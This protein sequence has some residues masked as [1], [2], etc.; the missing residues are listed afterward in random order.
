MHRNSCLLFKRY[1]SAHIRPG[2]RV[3]EV[4]PD[5][6]PSSYRRLT[7]IDVACWDSVDFP[8]RV[9]VTYELAEPY[10]FPIPDESYDV[11]LSG[12]V[13]EHVPKIWRWMPELARVTRPGGHIITV[14]PVSWP[15]HEAPHDCWR[16]YPAGLSAL[17]EDI[18]LEVLVAEWGSV[19]LEPLQRRVPQSLRRRPLWQQLSTLFLLL[20]N[21]VGVPTQGAFDTVAVGRKPEAL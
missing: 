10:S 12:Q 2:D 8:G 20:H 15:Y 16:I 9:P 13:I 18:G 14:A 3:L 1:A 19:E 17:Y 6:S 5:E 4:G 11:V 21:H 7:D